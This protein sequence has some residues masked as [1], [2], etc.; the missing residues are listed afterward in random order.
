MDA[1]LGGSTRIALSAI[2]GL[3]I[4]IGDALAPALQAMLGQ[5]TAVVGGLTK[6]AKDNQSL[7]VSVAKGVAIFAGAGV[8][9]YG[10]GVALGKVS[11]LLGFAIN[12]WVA[13]PLLVVGAVAAVLSFAGVFE[14]LGAIFSTTLGGMY[15]AIA[16]GDLAG[17]MEVLWLGLQAGWLTGVA[18]FMGTFEPWIDFVGN[19]FSYLSANVLTI[20]DGMVNG[21]LAAW[22]FLESTI[23]QGWNYVQSFFTK[24]FDLDAENRKVTDE[25][26][27][28]SR[29]RELS[30]V[31]RFAEADKA[32]AERLG[33]STADSYRAAADA[34]T[35]Q[36]ND[37]SRGANQTKV[38]GAQAAELLASIGKATSL[39]QL[40]DMYGEFEALSSTGRLSPEQAT[41]I[42][43]ALADAQNRIAMASR[44]AGSGAGI[45]AGAAAAGVGQSQAEVAGTFSAAAVGGMGV[46]S[47][48]AQRQVDLL[49]DIA[50]NTAQMTEGGTVKE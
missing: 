49:S 29:Q 38:F 42:E 21:M 7:I 20:W 50:A 11:A 31:D 46:G 15:D 1:G 28:R 37:R 16:T 33:T 30:T 2:E 41:S 13:V 14:G 39:D 35:A 22:D 12:F 24:G 19:V 6:F 18:N 27:A 3:A 32:A 25:M 23:R 17:A 47:S 45:A 40:R 26:G 10:V 36:L 4:A 5:I 44:P 48:L 8:A 9:I 43:D 34:A